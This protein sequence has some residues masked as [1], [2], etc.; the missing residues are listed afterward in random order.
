MQFD[1][2]YGS[3]TKKHPKKQTWSCVQG[4]TSVVTD[5]MWKSLTTK[6][7]YN[8]RVTAIRMEKRITLD[9]YPKMF[10][11]VQNH[12]EFDNKAYSHIFTTTRYPAWV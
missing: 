10:I 3:G 11:K 6:P 5:L 12:P 8:H 4:G 7:L 1:Y 2:P 9:M